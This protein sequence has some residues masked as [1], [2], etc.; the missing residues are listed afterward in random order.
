MAECSNCGKTFLIGGRSIDGYRYCGTRCSDSHWIIATADQ[1]PAEVIQPLVE[2]WRHGPCPICRRN[3]SPIDVHA[4]H[5]VMSFLIATQWSTRRHVCCRRCGQK[6]QFLAI[7]QS[8]VL[9]WWGIPW[10]LI[11]TPI[12]IVR[13][14]VGASRRDKD[15]ATIQ[16]EQAVRRQVAAQQLQRGK[17]GTSA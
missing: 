4:E 13:N 16:F 9:G 1:L 12:Q 10:G 15:S 8:S 6:K 7:L 5:R 3:D 2:K 14:F 11:F 17:A